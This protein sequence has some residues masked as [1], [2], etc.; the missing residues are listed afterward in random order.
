MLNLS[1]NKITKIG[2]QYLADVLPYNIV[3]NSLFIYLV[4]IIFMDQTLEMLV[5]LWNRIDDGTAYDFFYYS[6]N[7]LVQIIY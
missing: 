6:D 1:S 7:K 5:F 3:R 4:F 2:A